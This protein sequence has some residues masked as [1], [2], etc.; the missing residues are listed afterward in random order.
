M[1]ALYFMF[2]KSVRIGDFDDFL[3]CVKAILPWLFALYHTQYSRWMLVFIQDFS[4]LERD[5][6]E[7][8]KAFKKGF[9]TVRKTNCVFPN[10]GIDQAHDQNNKILK[11]DGGVI[12]ILDNPTALLKWPICGPVISEIL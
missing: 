8:C 12:G 11:A 6:N 10:M 2:I 5:H 7:T 4:T 1:E 3:K 9:F